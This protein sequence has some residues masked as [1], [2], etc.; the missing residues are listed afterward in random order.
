[1][2]FLERC[3]RAS[4]GCQDLSFEAVLQR[5]CCAPWT[6]A[7]A[8]SATSME[9]ESGRGGDR[10]SGGGRKRL[11]ILPVIQPKP[12]WC[13]SDPA[14]SSTAEVIVA[15][16][17]HERLGG[18]A[19]CNDEAVHP[20]EKFELPDNWPSDSR[21]TSEAEPELWV[22]PELT[23]EP[24]SQFQVKVASRRRRTPPGAPL[25][26]T[27]PQEPRSSEVTGAIVKA[28]SLS[29][30]DFVEAGEGG[31]CDT[32]DD[33]P[34]TRGTLSPCR[35]LSLVTRR[36]SAASDESWDSG[37]ASDFQPEFTP[38]H[39]EAVLAGHP[40]G[41]AE[42]DGSVECQATGALASSALLKPLVSMADPMSGNP[43][44]E[45]AVDA[46]VA[47][48]VQAAITD[49][50]GRRPQQDR[51]KEEEEEVRAKATLPSQQP[52]IAADAVDETGAPNGAAVS[53]SC[54]DSWAASASAEQPVLPCHALPESAA[55]ADDLGAQAASLAIGDIV[56]LGMSAMPEFRGKP[57]VVKQVHTTHCT[58]IVLEEAMRFGLGES[59]PSFGDITLQSSKLRIGSK[60]VLDGLTGKQTRRMNSLSGVVI[61]RP[62]DEQDGHIRFITKASAPTEPLLVVL[63]KF[64][65]ARLAGQASMLVEPRHLVSYEEYVDKL[66][67][68]F[69]GGP[70]SFSARLAS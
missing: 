47:D 70:T 41:L 53:D 23:P 64:D 60:V 27:P 17:G 52:E 32:A 35:K 33:T 56:R 44:A 48:M 38:E 18:S 65:D 16:Q 45:M 26:Q 62:R 51:E 39:E 55:S 3:C 1:M 8:S 15:G 67:A 29:L 66:S 11:H 59:W 61:A 28:A 69:E 43:A 20:L 24:G 46:W 14:S 19:W 5:A 31:K 10:N 6:P 13:P 42:G 12:R 57:A 34:S 22:G 37:G 40:E 30:E 25:P 2:E 36:S 49:A 58:V 21:M 68:E 50:A 63:V 54:V 4:M 7:S 9:M